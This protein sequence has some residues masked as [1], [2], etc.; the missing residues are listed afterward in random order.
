[1]IPNLKIMIILELIQKV[2][3]LLQKVTVCVHCT[4]SNSALTRSSTSNDTK[5]TDEK[6]K[7]LSNTKNKNHAISMDASQSREN[8]ELKRHTDKIIL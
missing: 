4:G 5:V 8:L 2:K 6:K 7:V 3:V 1:M